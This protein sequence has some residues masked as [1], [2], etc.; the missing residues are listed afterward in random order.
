M[1]ARKATTSAAAKL[2]AKSGLAGILAKASSF[3]K[4]GAFTR[5]SQVGLGVVVA[6]LALYAAYLWFLQQ[7]DKKKGALSVLV[8]V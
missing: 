3:V 2:I 6:V 8:G 4:F 1:A 7:P 5:E